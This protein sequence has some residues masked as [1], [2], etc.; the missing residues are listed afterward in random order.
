MTEFAALLDLTNQVLWAHFVVF[1]R[2]A[3]AMALFPGLGEQSIPVRFK[4]TLALV[5]T[6]VVTPAL[7]PDLIKTTN[8][9]TVFVQIIFIETG[10]GTLIGIG[11]RLFLLALQTAG[12][13]AAQVTS[14]SQILGSAGVTPL[15][16]MGHLLAI[17]ALTLGMILGL[18]VHLA[19]MLVLTYDVLPTAM[20]PSAN[21][22]AQWGIHNVAAAFSLAFTL[23]APF[24]IVSVLYNVTLGVIN[25]AMPQMMVVFIGA[26]V[27]TLTG[28]FLLF[29]LSPIMLRLWVE[30]FQAFMINPFEIDR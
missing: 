25:R 9:I 6:V 19:T 16:A 7:A 27:I 11:L 29:L 21:S 5:F 2:V 20:V 10:I 8:S 1:L 13:I 26:P 30:G 18:H 22:V 24:V 23:A 17:G 15:P 4:L 14:L 12:S 3:P 28:L